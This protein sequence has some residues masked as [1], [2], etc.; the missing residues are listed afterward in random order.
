M[1]SKIPSDNNTELA[2]YFGASAYYKKLAFALF[3]GILFFGYF[4]Q[5]SNFD[6]HNK[7]GDAQSLMNVHLYGEHETKEGAGTLMPKVPQISN[8]VCCVMSS[9]AGFPPLM[10]WAGNLFHAFDFNLTHYRWM[11][12]GTFFIT[13]MLFGLSVEKIFGSKIA[14]ASVS[15]TLLLPPLWKVSVTQIYNFGD[16][17]LWAMILG[18]LHYSN[19]L[20]NFLSTIAVGMFLI[21]LTTYEFVF[22]GLIL[23][24][25]IGLRTSLKTA[26]M[27]VLSGVLATIAA[28]A[29]KFLIDAFDKQSLTQVVSEQ[30]NRIIFRVSEA[31]STSSSIDKIIGGFSAYPEFLWTSF[32]RHYFSPLLL[33]FIMVIYVMWTYQNSKSPKQATMIALALSALL[34]A[35]ASWT[36]IFVQHTVIHVNSIVNRHWL[37]LA[38]LVMGLSL[39]LIYEFVLVLFRRKASSIRPSAKIYALGVIN[40]LATASVFM[41]V[42]QNFMSFSSYATKL[43]WRAEVEEIRQIC[44]ATDADRCVLP[45][46]NLLRAAFLHQNKEFDLGALEFIVK[47]K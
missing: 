11:L 6:I 33:I 29:T 28:V 31:Q 4:S 27:G 43:T 46:Q 2:Q 3:F 19:T 21:A 34:L 14:I 26:T 35:S 8:G 16:L 1:L 17:M 5:V 41:I 13:I 12:A 42:G 38:A 45:N 20:R 36:T 39:Y 9:Y 47:E 22:F 23:V 18:A 24:A 44:K 7:Y 15:S 30:V 32:T 40:L 25:A 10:N 37:Y